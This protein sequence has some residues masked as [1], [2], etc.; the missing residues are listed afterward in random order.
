MAAASLSASA[1]PKAFGAL[2][3]GGAGSEVLRDTVIATGAGRVWCAVPSIAES[4]AVAGL[5]ESFILDPWPGAAAALDFLSRSTESERGDMPVVLLRSGTILRRGAMKR[6]MIRL[7]AQDGLVIPTRHAAA[8]TAIRL[9]A[10]PRATIAAGSGVVVSARL[11]RWLVRDGWLTGAPAEIARIRQTGAQLHALRRALAK[12]SGA[13]HLER[14]TITVL[15]PANN[16]AAYLGD[17]LRA[18]QAQTVAPDEV[19]VVDDGSGDGT[20]DIARAHGAR[21][22]RP[23]APQG[24]KAI[25]SNCGLPYVRTE[26]VMVLDADTQLHPEAIEHLSDDLR[27]GIDATSGACLPLLQQ[28]IWSRGRAVEYSMAIRIHKPVQQAL[29]TLVVMSGCISMF[30]T[31]VLRRLG[32]FSARTLAEDIDATWA[33][34]LQGGKAGYTPK[35]MSY[36]AEPATWQLYRAQMRRWASGFYQTVGTHRTRV[37]HKPGLALIV[38]A[39][40]WDVITVPILA[41]SLVVAAVTRNFPVPLLAM[42]ALFLLLPI[43]SGGTV[44]GWRR[45]ARNF[46]AYLITMWVNSYFY[47]EAFFIEWIARRPRVAWVK[48]H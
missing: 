41:V 13:P 18:I 26:A 36:P 31:S 21:V 4:T 1:S 16:E 20:G 32:G 12:P 34:Q 35:A 11:L 15:I 38:V 39:S 45:T 6:A 2:V 17:T 42:F 23:D 25:A 14:P 5:A 3:A 47:V 30:R 22:I 10:F 40:L 37:R 8:A 48:G 24:S 43:I 46:P 29:G 44:I 28:G 7:G 27:R 19:L 33:Y 9:R